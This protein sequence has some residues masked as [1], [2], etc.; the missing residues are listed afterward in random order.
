MH[1]RFTESQMQVPQQRQLRMI[2]QWAAGN[3][4]EAVE[5]IVRQVKLSICNNNLPARGLFHVNRMLI[6]LAIA[7]NFRIFHEVKVR[8]LGYGEEMVE[9]M[10]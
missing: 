6:L 10:A 5:S 8:N 2:W 3:S 9:T 7:C 1:L 4:R